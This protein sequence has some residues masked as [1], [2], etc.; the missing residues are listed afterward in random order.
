MLAHVGSA[1]ECIQ[2]LGEAARANAAEGIAVE[3][4]KANAIGERRHVRLCAQWPKVRAKRTGW[5]ETKQAKRIIRLSRTTTRKPADAWQID[6]PYL[7]Q[8]VSG[9]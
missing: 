3:Q 1:S 2:F 6:G 9:S 7:A 8:S 4:A 5:N